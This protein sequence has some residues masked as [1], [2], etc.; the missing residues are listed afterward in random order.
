MGRKNNLLSIGEVAKYTGATIRAL[1]Y[2]ERIKLLEPLYVDP[3]SGYRYY[4]FKQT[5][6]VELIMFCIEL[7]IP[8]KKLSD[9][10]DGQDVMNIQDFL[11]Y[12]KEEAKKKIRTLEKG[13]R[14]IDYFEQKMATQENYPIGQLFT[15]ELPEKFYYAIPYEQ[16]LDNVNQY[17]VAKLFYKNPY[18]E[19]AD[20]TFL[21]YGYLCE[22]SSSGVVRY[23]FIEVPQEIAKADCKIIPAGEYHCVRSMVRQIGH[24]SEIFKDYLA[25]RDSYIAIEI[26]IFS[27]KLSINKPVNELR[28]R[29]L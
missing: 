23:A 7:G 27:G 13:L 3:N 24:V 16:S 8:L 29:E 6:L 17:E 5:F 21:E 1:R 28:I 19:V 12:G 14:F 15:R 9:F 18:S 26:E 2:Y 10:I 22:Y 25:D 4:S 20:D 11:E